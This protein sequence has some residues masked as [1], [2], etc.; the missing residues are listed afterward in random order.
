[1]ATSVPQEQCPSLCQL[2][3]RDPK[4]KWKCVD[5]DLLM[6]IQCKNN[7]HNKI[8]TERQH[9]IIDIKEVTYVSHQAP[10]TDVNITSDKKYST[11][12]DYIRCLAVS[13]DGSL[14]IGDGNVVFY[15]TAES[16]VTKTDLTNAM[17]NLVQQKD[18]KTLVSNI[19]QKLLDHFEEKITSK[20]ECKIREAT[21]K[22]DDKLDTLMIEN[23]DLR[24]RIRA[25]DRVIENLVEKVGD[26][27]NRSIDALKLANYNEQYSRKHNIKNAKLS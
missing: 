8:R 5:C 12:M 20:F 18:L 27:N 16:H 15:P 1:M 3:N 17:V 23:E 26:N 7:I 21:G 6:C 11:R 22:L 13:L 24:E 10:A 25:K 19:V 14:W 2:C 9:S 4:I